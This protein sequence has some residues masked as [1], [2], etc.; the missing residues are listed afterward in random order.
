[1]HKTFCQNVEITKGIQGEDQNLHLR[2][3]QYKQTK[4]PVDLPIDK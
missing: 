3:C 2:Q 1:M 4:D